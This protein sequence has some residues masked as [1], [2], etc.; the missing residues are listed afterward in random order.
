MISPYIVFPVVGFFIGWITNVIA[1]T[2]L[3]HPRKKILG[4]QGIIPHRRKELAKRISEASVHITPSWMKKI[5]D[6]P[7]IG[8]KIK[9]LYKES[10]EA[11]VNKMS[12]EELEMIV[13]KTV[14]KEFRI[15]EI[16][17]G[18]LGALIGALQ[19]LLV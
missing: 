5:H 4:F 13:K 6:M 19:L 16:M 1:I 17:G 3:F 7:V 2:F 18:I 9:D 12:N 14:N 8:N 10:V 11:E 15:V